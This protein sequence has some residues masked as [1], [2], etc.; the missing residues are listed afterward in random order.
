[1]SEQRCA[2]H[3][4]PVAQPRRRRQTHPLLERRR[5]EVLV[6]LNLNPREARTRAARH[7][8][9]H[10]PAA[11]LALRLHRVTDLRVEVALAGEIILQAVHAFRQQLVVEAAL[12][13]NRQHAPQ[14]PLRHVCAF[15]THR[16]QRPGVD[17]QARRDAVQRLVVIQRH[18]PHRGH[19]VALLRVHPTHALQPALHPRVGHLAPFVPAPPRPAP[20]LPAHQRAPRRFADNPLGREFR[21]SIH[22]RSGEARPSP[23][24]DD[25]PQLDLFG[26]LPFQ[27]F[28]ANL[29]RV[30]TV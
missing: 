6:A 19:Q 2:V 8:V 12:L 17:R 13:E 25:E 27:R 1:M 20:A 4:P 7:P 16:D 30:K 15:R 28:V 18:Q 24:L 5:V 29:G 14:R 26:R 3:A 10:R 9:H 11:G 22:L 23:G 21:L